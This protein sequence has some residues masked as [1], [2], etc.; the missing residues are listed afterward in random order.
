MSDFGDYVADDS[1][2]TAPPDPKALVRVL[3]RMVRF[4]LHER[5][6][7]EHERFDDLTVEQK[8]SV[9]QLFIER[10]RREGSMR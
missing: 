4:Y 8:E 10:L 1:F 5:G 9:M 2:D 6:L 3:G 7:A